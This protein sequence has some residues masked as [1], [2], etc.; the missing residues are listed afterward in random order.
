MPSHSSP[1]IPHRRTLVS[2]GAALANY[3]DRSRPW[4]GDRNT[5]RKTWLAAA[6]V[7]TIMQPMATDCRSMAMRSLLQFCDIIWAWGPRSLR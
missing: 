3:L 2:G 1:G 7:M 6:P 4:S 5:S